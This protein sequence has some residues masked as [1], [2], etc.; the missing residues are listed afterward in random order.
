MIDLKFWEENGYV[1]VP[2]AVPPENCRAA[3]EAVWDFLDMDSNNPDSWY[4]PRRSTIMVELYHCQAFWDNRQYPRVYQVFAEILGNQKLWVTLHR[5]SMTPP[6][7][8]DYSVN[9]NEHSIHFDRCPK[10]TPHKKSLSRAHGILYLT[11][12]DHTQG[13]LRVVPGSHRKIQDWLG[14]HSVEPDLEKFIS[15]ERTNA[16]PIAAKSGSLIIWHPELLHGSSPNFTNHP[17]VAQYIGME[18]ADEKNIERRNN[19]IERWCERLAGFEI[20]KKVIGKEHYHSKTAVL[21]PLGRK[22]LG[23]ESW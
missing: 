9:E 19:R 12:V 16:I 21:T 15:Q 7:R 18:I 3:E 8:V 14:F 17:R 23:V 4:R 20:K 5:A 22:L 6:E 10:F 11:D 1:I 13:A 2:G